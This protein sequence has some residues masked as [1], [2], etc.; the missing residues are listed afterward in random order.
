MVMDTDMK[1]MQAASIQKK[2]STRDEFPL[3]KTSIRRTLKSLGLWK[4]VE[5]AGHDN[6][7]DYAANEGRILQYLEA[8]FAQE[9][10]TDLILMGY[11]P[12]EA[13][14]STL[15]S[16]LRTRMASTS[17]QHANSLQR[18]WLELSFAQYGSSRKLLERA[19][20]LA[21]QFKLTGQDI[22]DE[23]LVNRV[24]QAWGKKYPDEERV[25]RESWDL[26]QRKKDGIFSKILEK[27]AEE[28]VA[29]TLQT[30]AATP[31]GQSNSPR[32]TLKEK[33]CETCKKRFKPKYETN[34]NCLECWKKAKKAKEAEEAKDTAQKGGDKSKS[35]GH[36]KKSPRQPRQGNRSSPT[37]RVTQI[38]S[39]AAMVHQEDSSSSEEYISEL[40]ILQEVPATSPGQ[41]IREVSA[42]EAMY[43][44]HHGPE[45]VSQ[46]TIQSP[47]PVPQAKHQSPEPVSQA[48]EVQTTLTTVV[49]D[50][51]EPEASDCYAVSDSVIQKATML[52]LKNEYVLDS[53]SNV[54][55]TNNL[56]L[57][58]DYR[59]EASTVRGAG[60][61]L[62]SAEGRGNHSVEFE[63]G[64][65]GTTR[66]V[67]SNVIY[68][69]NSPVNIISTYK[70]EMNGVVIDGRHH[71]LVAMSTGDP[72]GSY[73]W[74][75][76]LMVVNLAGEFRQQ[77][78]VSFLAVMEFRKLHECL[79]HA[80]PNVVRRAAKKDG[81]HLTNIPDNWHCRACQLGGS[82][83]QIHRSPT[84]RS[85]ILFEICLVDF[86]FVKPQGW[87]MR[88]GA[89]VFTEE[90]S[91]YKWVVLFN[92]KAEF[93]KI[94]TN[95]HT[96]IQH[97]TGQKILIY[98]IDGEKS[99]TDG[100]HEDWA[101]AEGVT[102]RT[103]PP[104]THEPM[105]A[106]ERAIKTIFM[107]ARKTCL[108]ANLPEFLWPFALQYLVFIHNLTPQKRWNWTC[109]YERFAGAIQLPH[110]ARFPGY[111]FLV[112]W[113]T[114]GYVNRPAELKAK[115]AKFAPTADECYFVGFYK[116][117]SGHIYDV[118]LPEL[119]P[120]TGGKPRRK[121]VHG[122]VVTARDVRFFDHL[123]R[124]QKEECLRT[125]KETQKKGPIFTLRWVAPAI[126]LPTKER[127][128]LPLPK[129][130]A[131]GPANP[132]SLPTP[133]PTPSPEP[134]PEPTVAPPEEEA[135]SPLLDEILM[136]EA[137][138]E[139]LPDDL[140]TRAVSTTKEPRRSVRT[141]K[142]SP[143]AAANMSY[144]T[145]EC[146][147]PFDPHASCPLCL[148]HIDVPGFLMSEPPP[149]TYS[150]A[151]NHPKW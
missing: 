19:V 41:E 24:L 142:P 9:T 59:N 35:D 49:M 17:S 11:D 128:T 75:N 104:Y 67:I 14:P 7:A 121:G 109:P 112:K 106:K 134:S 111:K 92:S 3:W 99:L 101:P 50:E 117:T 145:L 4:F 40:H 132:Q 144:L 88:T 60:D 78:H 110:E 71:R 81:I 141:K 52:S 103:S 46:A 69:P 12:D 87:G 138:M 2:L 124:P 44:P 29:V 79:G 31:T 47:E 72:M 33:K 83:Q 150:A 91:D 42:P 39:K 114:L 97:S 122:E 61:I 146:Q 53:G 13:S 27:A 148:S 70:L 129:V 32:S 77:C 82:H 90:S 115:G 130:P 36:S 95:F 20:W 25:L 62:A 6:D 131:K 118:W 84:L 125:E 147:Q 26:K 137:P 65:R 89:A 151:R 1:L 120:T 54:D 51:T 37:R 68:N 116:S 57:V 56:S 107:M 80:A 16:L 94:I 102:I 126:N 85:T 76:G 135:R 30:Q 64:Q 74:V 96:R 108:D 86:A 66:Y 28:D 119:R 113:G 73:R 143:K 23:T 149:K 140:P 136:A 38:G 100:F 10:L 105:G 139:A 133:L 45:P 22:T 58:E 5:T 8:C 18:D 55:I 21:T 123:S 98:Q 127:S 43:M 63:N 34:R 48:P 15:W 93:T